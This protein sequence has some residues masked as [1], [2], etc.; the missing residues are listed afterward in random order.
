[1]TYFFICCIVIEVIFVILIEI[2][3]FM[4]ILY[5]VGIDY[6]FRCL[7]LVVFV[8]RVFDGEVGLFIRFIAIFSFFQ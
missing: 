7:G 6:V 1:M 4:P 8:D 2:R 3:E 5:G